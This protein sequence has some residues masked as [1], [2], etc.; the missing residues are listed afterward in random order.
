MVRESLLTPAARP[1]G[2]PEISSPRAARAIASAA[3]LKIALLLS[4]TFW[5]FQKTG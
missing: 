2:F 4:V 5:I 3:R 1:K